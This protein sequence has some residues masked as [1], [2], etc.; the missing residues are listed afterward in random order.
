[1]DFTERVHDQWSTQR[2]DID[3]GTILTIGRI[4]RIAALVT[5]MSEDAFAPH[6]VTR[7]EYDLLSAL[8]RAGRPLR[9]N[10]VSTLTRASGAAITKRLDR[11]ARA[12]LVER[13]VPERDR[14]G[15]LL[16]LTAAGIELVD[17][18]FTEQVEREQSSLDGL[19]AEELD[20]LAEL[21]AVVLARLDPPTH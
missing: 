16:T 19:D 11:L 2:P 18:L 15:T 17:R 8:R 12:G 7:P 5:D 20:D 6:G 13:A 9:A 1:V 14:R 21:L 4:L 10:E 3:S